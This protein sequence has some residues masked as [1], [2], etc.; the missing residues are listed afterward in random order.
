MTHLTTFFFLV[1]C[2]HALAQNDTTLRLSRYF[3]GFYLGVNVGSQNLFGGSMVEGKD[4][5]AQESRFVAEVVTGF[6]KQFLKD[7]LLAGAELQLG[8]TDGE[9][10][11]KEPSKPLT[12]N[13]KNNF[14]SG[15][16]LTLGA[17]FC[18]RKNILTYVYAFE[19][20]R[21]FE[22]TIQDAFGQYK[23]QDE[24]GMLKYGIGIEAHLWKGLNACVTIGRL[25]VDFGDLET[26]IDVEDKWDFSFGITYQ[27]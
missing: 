4:V 24:Q 8:F 3:D 21:K 20:E 15:Y 26:N 2:T 13:Y 17:I 19:T 1:F 11:H 25:R 12:I 6:R 16:G 23:Q 9:L 27:F 10:I 14:Q 18:K 5:L 22:V 7:R